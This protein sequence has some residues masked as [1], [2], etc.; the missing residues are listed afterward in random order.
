MDG[1]EPGHN[2]LNLWLTKDAVSGVDPRVNMGSKGSVSMMTRDRVVINT[3]G[4]GGWG[5]VAVNGLT[6]G[7]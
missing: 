6:N 7:H 5:Q 4:G 2:G 1:G 3:P